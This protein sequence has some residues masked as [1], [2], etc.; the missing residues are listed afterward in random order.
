MKV[1]LTKPEISKNDIEI[2]KNSLQSGWL[3]HGKYN[4]KF[5]I[6]FAK[7]VGTKY[8]VAVNSCTSALELAL[9]SNNINEGEI[10]IPSFT[11]VSTANVVKLCGCDPVF[12]DVD[13]KTRNIKAE[14]VEKAITNK[15]KALIAV[16]FAGLPCD[17]ISLKKVCKK[18]KILF[19]EDSAECIGGLQ[20]KHVAGS[21]GVGCF[22]FYPTK[23]LTTG[24][25]GMVTS[26][27]LKMIKKIKALSAHGIKSSAFERKKKK[28][29]WYRN[30]TYVGRNFRMPD[31]LAALGIS[32]LKKINIMNKKRN[33]IAKIYE[34]FF[35]GI[36]E[37]I[38]QKTNNNYYHSYQMYS[39]CIK[40]IDK[41][42]FINFLNK[43]GIQAS[44]HFDPPVHKQTAY[45]K[46]SNLR[47]KN[48]EIL[49]KNSI[50]LPMYSNMSEKM[51]NFVAKTFVKNYKKF[52]R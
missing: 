5:E 40:G 41:K 31:P 38:L 16:H 9:W 37:I 2:V 28:I 49:S 36:K 14:E 10:I 29:S 27:S 51:A 47:L 20:K 4:K 6:E 24:E 12:I 25:G 32:Q 39:I 30:A 19:I 7:F 1:P 48:T 46:Y 34:K 15:T 52:L 42:K 45:K 22:S 44:S 50:S 26:N 8:A 3:A 43:K 17:I 23:N 11:W 21:I 13:L 35:L 33:I 18:Y